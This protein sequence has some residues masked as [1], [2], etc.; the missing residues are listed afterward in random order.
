MGEH[1]P[2]PEDEYAVRWTSKYGGGEVT[3]RKGSKEAAIDLANLAD[4]HG[5][6]DVEVLTRRISEWEPMFARLGASAS[7]A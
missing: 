5:H 4:L 3:I 1:P 2:S 7:D 6:S